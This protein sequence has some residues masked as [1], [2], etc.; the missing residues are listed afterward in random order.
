[1]FLTVFTPLYNRESSIRD[2]YDSLCNQTCKEFE[3][4]VVNDGSTDN[5][6]AIMKEILTH[7]NNSFPIRYIERENLGL[8]ATLNEGIENALG[9]MFMRLDSDDR[10]LPEAVDLIVRYYTLIQ[11]RDDICALVFRSVD[12]NNNPIGSHPFA[13]SQITDFGEFRDR[14]RAQGDRSEVMKM[15]VYKHYRYPVIPGEKFCPEG[16]IWL[17][18]AQKYQAYFM[19]EPIYQ[20]GAPDDSITSSIYK[21]QKS[22]CKG[23]TLHYRALVSNRK[24][25]FRF[26][27]LGSIKYFRFVFY[28]GENPFKKIPLQFILFGLP[29]GIIVAIYDY[30]NNRE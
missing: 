9:K 24:L 22:N 16:Y 3:W 28:S 7:H 25:S 1:M 4:L 23:M 2:V 21:Y 17:K 20:K 30:F 11:N 10:A 8:M 15:D 27:M 26:R 12:L 5:S 29:L 13:E 19:R 18:I 6:G 14:Y